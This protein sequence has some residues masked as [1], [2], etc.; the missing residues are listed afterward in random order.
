MAKYKLQAMSVNVLRQI[1][2]IPGWAKSIDDIYRGGKL[3]VDTIPAV[4]AETPI[5]DPIEFEMDGP[6]RDLC[7]VAFNFALSKE[8]IRPDEW[9]VDILE[10]LEFVQKPKAPAALPAVP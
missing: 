6:S 4:V 9:V 8:A 2:S 10:T 1:L 3:L 5:R 7:K